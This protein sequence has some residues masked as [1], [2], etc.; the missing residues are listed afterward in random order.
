MMFGR[1]KGAKMT[2][3]R[4]VPGTVGVE[5]GV[6]K[7]DTADLFLS[8]GIKHLHL[9]DPWCVG[10][11]KATAEFGGFTNYLARYQKLVGSDDPR[12]FQNYYDGV[13]NTVARRFKHS[14]V[15]IHRQTS[16]EFFAEH[17]PGPPQFDWV[18]LDG[19]HAYAEVMNDLI[20]AGQVSKG[21]IYGDDY[22]NK[23]GV[24]KAVND[25]V[26]Q[27]GCN[28]QVYGGNQYELTDAPI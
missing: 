17:I 12:A 7:G 2:A 11:Y 3:D 6:W 1:N 25:Y 23:S 4:I 16:R 22:G 28:I 20:C 27:R 8:R 9:V 21:P 26:D 24:T 19:S 15:T 5:I 14:P 18:Y 10:A 13:A